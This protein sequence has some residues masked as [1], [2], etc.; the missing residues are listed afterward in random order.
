M[1]LRNWTPRLQDLTHEEVVALHLERRRRRLD[2]SQGRRAKEK[3]RTIQKKETKR[4][5]EIK[6]D[7]EK[8]RELLKLLGEDV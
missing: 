7:P 6:R 3:A 8:I 2:W 4:L 5:A 1:R